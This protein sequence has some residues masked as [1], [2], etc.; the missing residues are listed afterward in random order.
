MGK[1]WG[2][3]PW[4]AVSMHK[5]ILLPKHMYMSVVWWDIVSRVQARNVLQSLQSGYL[6]AAVGSMKTT[7]TQVI[8]VALCQTPLNLAAIVAAYRLKCQGEWRDTGL[9][10]TK[11]DSFRKYSFTLNKD[12]VLKKISVGKAI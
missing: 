8:E 9:G 6:R 2:I 4:L 5:A 3:N 7:P 12:R 11:L 1:T 10:H